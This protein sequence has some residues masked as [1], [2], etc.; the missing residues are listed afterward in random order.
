MAKHQNEGSIHILVGY[1]QP[2]RWSLSLFILREPGGD[3]VKHP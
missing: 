1:L 2:L 3:A